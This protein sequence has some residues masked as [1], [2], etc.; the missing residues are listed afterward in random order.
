MRQSVTPDYVRRRYIF[1][2]NACSTNALGPVS[3]VRAMA[4]T[5][6]LKF[7]KGI[8]LG[9]RLCPETG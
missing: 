2:T 5:A 9:Q 7:V 6:G 8:R 3:K 4:R 1:S